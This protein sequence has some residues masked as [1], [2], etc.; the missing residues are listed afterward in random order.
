[1]KIRFSSFS[2]LLFAVLAG[3]AACTSTIK[4]SSSEVV[5]EPGTEVLDSPMIAEEPTQ[6]T[7]PSFKFPNSRFLGYWVGDFNPS[8]KDADKNLNEFIVG[9]AYVWNRVN[10]INISIDS[11]TGEKVYGHSVVAGNDRPFE[12]TLSISE[13]KPTY[14]FEVREPGDD[15][16]DGVFRFSIESGKL[17]GTW[18]AYKDLEIKKRDYALEKKSFTYDP[19]L[20]LERNSF[21]V[22]WKNYVESTR[23][24]EWEEGQVETWTERSFATTSSDIFKI[25]ASNTVLTGKDVENLYK[26]D[27]VVIRN[28]IYA[29]HGYSFKNRPLRVFFDAQSWYIPVHTH[30]RSDFTE[31]EKQNIELLLRYEK[32]ASEYYDEFGRG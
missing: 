25:N 27:L 18:E 2:T 20:E 30:I 9:E 5:I 32:N 31:I 12:G 14:Q 13:E 16:Y 21:Y 6:A 7:T 28:T 4:D 19:N 23:S 15:K 10:K 8:G 3:G 1:M 24:E 22:D 17:I 11:I 26:S 29:R